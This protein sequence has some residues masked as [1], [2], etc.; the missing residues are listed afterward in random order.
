[1]PAWER[2][3]AYLAQEE[4]PANGLPRTN[5]AWRD[6]WLS[7]L[8]RF[9]NLA[10]PVADRLSIVYY[11]HQARLV[12]WDGPI[13]PPWAVRAYRRLSDWT[14]SSPPGVLLVGTASLTG[15]VHWA[16][17]PTCTAERP[18]D[19]SVTNA[20]TLEEVVLAHVET[21]D[22]LPR[23]TNPVC[24]HWLDV[25]SKATVKILIWECAYTALW[26]G[27]GYGVRFL[28]PPPPHILPTWMVDLGRYLPIG[29]L[30]LSGWAAYMID[31][32]RVIL[33]GRSPQG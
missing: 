11:E 24:P 32:A 9:R 8:K 1:M 27:V 4:G 15:T 10:V 6:F 2:I 25:C 26:Y 12:L 14:R 13:S 18:L 28:M 29:T 22:L 7:E 21:H 16:P 23:S 31:T 5:S 30:I 3:S 19:G 20:S 17:E 33:Y